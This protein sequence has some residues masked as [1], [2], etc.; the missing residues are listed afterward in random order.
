MFYWHFYGGILPSLLIFVLV[1]I[2][3]PKDKSGTS[4]TGPTN[5]PATAG[6][7][8]TIHTD[9]GPKPGTMGGGGYV[10]PKK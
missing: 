2:T 5:K 4:Y 7:K 6:T 1:R 9:K 3:M 10:I 8:V